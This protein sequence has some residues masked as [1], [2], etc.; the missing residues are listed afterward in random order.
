MSASS[1]GEL[2]ESV[3]GPD[4]R[5]SRF[6]LLTGVY[7]CYQCKQSTRVSAVGLAGY[8]ERDREYGDYSEIG[9]GVLLTGITALNARAAQA[10][11]LRAPWMHL[12]YSQTAN[13]TY[14]ANHCEHCDA[15]IG[16]WFIQEA[17]E[18]FG[19]QSMDEAKRLAVEWI[20]GAI[21]AEDEGGM[22]ASWLDELL[23]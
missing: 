20:E 8:E 14:L 23:A 12:A 2:P 19:P 3:H 13:A 21:E 18:A 17:G 22:M 4:F 7:T 9:D 11:A 15:M 16:A 1:L 10:V 6:A 5:A